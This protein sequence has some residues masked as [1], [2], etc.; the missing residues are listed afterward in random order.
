[1]SATDMDVRTKLGRTNLV[2]FPVRR[3]G[4]PEDIAHAAAFL[5]SDDA[6]YVTGQVLVVDGGLMD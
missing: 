4:L 6:G 5:S 3:F 2:V 1:M